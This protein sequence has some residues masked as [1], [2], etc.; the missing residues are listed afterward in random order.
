LQSNTDANAN[1]NE[2]IK[3]A[4]EKMWAISLARYFSRKRLKNATESNI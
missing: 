2:K 4:L 1:V 3:E